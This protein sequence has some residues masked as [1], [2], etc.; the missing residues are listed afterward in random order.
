MM[1]LAPLH[2]EH[3]HRAPMS[4]EVHGGLHSWSPPIV[5]TLALIVVALVYLRGWYQLRSAL[6]HVLS[7]WRLAAFMSGVFSLWAAVASPL[8]ILDHQ[9]LIAHMVQHLLLMTVAAPLILLGAPAITLLNGIPQRLVRSVLGS[10]LRHPPAQR[11]GRIVTHPVF[12]WLASTGAVIG[13]HV[14]VLFALG[15]R[16]E[17]WLPSNICAFSWQAFCSGGQ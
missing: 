17:R 9:L 15:M 1:L 11:V 10:L 16:S 12:C 7:V 13:W 8:A 14:P 4:S 6:P 5:V 2:S 3:A